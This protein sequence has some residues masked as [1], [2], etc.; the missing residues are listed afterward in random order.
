MLAKNKSIEF[1]NDI[2]EGK[3]KGYCPHVQR[4]ISYS[5]GDKST[6]NVHFFSVD[7]PEEFSKDNC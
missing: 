2:T 4:A 1:L 7:F 3:M 5:S 6:I